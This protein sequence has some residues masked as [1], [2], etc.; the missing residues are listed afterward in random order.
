MSEH[1]LSF[2]NAFRFVEATTPFAE[3]EISNQKGGEA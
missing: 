3:K 1:E 2:T